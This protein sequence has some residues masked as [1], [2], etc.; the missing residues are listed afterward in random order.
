MW[1]RSEMHTEIWWGY[2][3]ERKHLQGFGLG[4]KIIFKSEMSLE[5]VEW[6]D[7]NFI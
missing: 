7:M 5:E 4:I 1:D 2:L 3:Q 6:E